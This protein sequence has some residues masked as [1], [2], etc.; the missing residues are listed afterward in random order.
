MMK[1]TSLALTAALA[2]SA[3]LVAGCTGDG[4]DPKPSTSSSGGS[5]T[6]T[7]GGGGASVE[8]VLGYQPPTSVGSAKAHFNPEFAAGDSELELNVASVRSTPTGAVL[9]YWVKDL[10]GKEDA[11]FVGRASDWEVFPT[12]VDTA[13]KKVYTVDTAGV[14][15][16]Q[17]CVCTRLSYA[18]QEPRL[19]T[20]LFAPLPDD[21]T[22]VEVRMKPFGAIKVPV[23]R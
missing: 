16:G 18:Y 13:G 1:R 14:R 4:D 8:D 12:L 6:T 2:C 21:V 20:A 17:S 23:T 3:L 11:M 19:N 15:E 22:Q 10:S 7:T 5:G 9:V